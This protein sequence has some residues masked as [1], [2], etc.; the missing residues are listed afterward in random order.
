MTFDRRK[1]LLFIIG[2]GSA[3]I[4]WRAWSVS[5]RFLATPAPA[6]AVEAE[7]TLPVSLAAPT[8]DFTALDKAVAL[9]E[10]QPW[11]RDPFDGAGRNSNPSPVP[12]ASAKLEQAPPAPTINFTGVSRTADRWLAAANNSIWTVGDVVQEKYKVVEITK[13]SITLVADSW[14]F[15]FALGEKVPNVHRWMEHP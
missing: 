3:F 13:S 7:P 15:T 2:L 6:S 5:G 4:A 8:E 14:A 1:K 9:A 12:I 11:G 10:S